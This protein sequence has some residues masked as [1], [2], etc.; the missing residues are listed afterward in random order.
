MF[1]V[2]L[3]LQGTR[4]YGWEGGNTDNADKSTKCVSLLWVVWLVTTTTHV[5]M[6]GLE[7]TQRKVWWHSLLDCGGCLSEG[8]E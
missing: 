6:L 5:T 4:C 8:M 7:A 2:I 1:V 3:T